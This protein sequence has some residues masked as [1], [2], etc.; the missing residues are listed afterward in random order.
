MAAQVTGP[1]ADRAIHPAIL[2]ALREH[3]GMQ[4]FR[5]PQDRII[6]DVLAGRDALVVMPTGGGKSLCYQLPALL[7]DGVTLVVSPLIALMK[8]QVDALRARGIAAGFVN[9][10][11]SWSEQCECLDAV[12]RGT[13][14]L[15]YIAPERFRAAGFMRALGAV[16]VALFAVDEAHCLSQWGHD[17]R[18]D[19]LRLGRALDAVGRP[20]CI[21]LTATATPDVQQDII[22]SLGLREPAVTVAGFARHNLAFSVRPIGRVSDKLDHISRMVSEHRTGIIYGATRK[23]VEKIS[24]ELSRE[25]IAHVMYHGGMSDVERGRAQERFMNREVNVAVATNAFGMG[26]DRADIRFVCHYEMPGSVEAYY[27]EGGR[28]GRDGLPAV[29][30]MLFSY[31]DKRVQEFFIE[32]AN[33]GRQ[34]V[35]DIFEALRRKAGDSNEVLLSIDEVAALLKRKVNPMAVGTAMAILSR[36]GLIER[37][38]VPGSRSRGSRILQPD[39]PFR[40]I[41]INEQELAEKAQRDEKKLQDV[42]RFAYAK[43]CRQQWI[44]SYFGERGTAPCGRCD[45]CAA[46]GAAPSTPLNADELLLVRKA[47]SVVAR[48][49]RR[50]GQDVWEP[51]YG[52]TRVIECALGKHSLKRPVAALE[53]LSTWGILKEFPRAFV[54]ELFDALELA[55]LVEVSGD[56]YALFGLTASGSQVMRGALTPA[57]QLPR[58]KSSNKTTGRA[59]SKSSAADTTE[60]A[61]QDKPLY[62]ALVAQRIAFAKAR[63]NVP[64]YTILSNRTLRELAFHKPATADE[65]SAIHGVGPQK[66]KSVIPAFLKVI[67]RFR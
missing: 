43:S 10:S 21:A 13:T 33:P 1:A 40:A 44:L 48:M 32:G 30:E 4:A 9:S 38:D 53:S 20:P 60:V 50:H 34:L 23:S 42:I 7:L 46:R 5:P 57:L 63:G 12:A 11:Q 45:I 41:E 59:S 3:F 22:S 19:Y 14:R 52:R 17:F 8:D 28:A 25:R 31:A 66:L 16:K 55:G 62:N 61:E 39:V 18:P 24:A 56:T 49:S 29:C 6:S 67:D 54:A 64:A 35:V 37:F 36:H 51:Q 58:P 15:L 26:I 2:P 47:L 65:A 27:Q